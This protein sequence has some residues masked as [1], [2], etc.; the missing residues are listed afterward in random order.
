MTKSNIIGIEVFVLTHLDCDDDFVNP[1]VHTT[2]K[3]AIKEM[4]IQVKE[5]QMFHEVRNIDVTVNEEKGHAWIFSKA[6]SRTW[7]IEKKSIR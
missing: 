1:S 3:K 2:F 5:H 4:R 7:S 6:T